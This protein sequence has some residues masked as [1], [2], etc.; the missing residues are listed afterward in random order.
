MLALADIISR[1]K[2]KEQALLEKKFHKRITRLGLII[3]FIPIILEIPIPYSK[4]ME[5]NFINSG[6][7]YIN[8][9]TS[10]GFEFIKTFL[11]SLL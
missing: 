8:N 7:S 3:A 2:E 10:L 4:L 11:N 1:N 6:I 5:I 9:L